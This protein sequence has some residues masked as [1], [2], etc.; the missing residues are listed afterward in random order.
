MQEDVFHKY[1]TVHGLSLACVPITVIKKLY[2]IMKVTVYISNE[3]CIPNEYLSMFQ[4]IIIQQYYDTT[5]VLQAIAIRS[6][7]PSAG[8]N[9]RM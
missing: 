7:F 8:H 3:S 4:I 2:K 6:W 1:Y 5:K 9:Q